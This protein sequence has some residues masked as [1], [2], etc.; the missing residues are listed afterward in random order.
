MRDSVKGFAEVYVDYINSL[1][2]VYQSGHPVIEGDEVGQ[3][4]HPFMNLC[5]LGLIPWMSGPCHVISPKMICFV[6]FPD[7]E[8]RLTGL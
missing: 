5:W 6:T 2:L 7:A 3:A 1:S 8:V 4:H